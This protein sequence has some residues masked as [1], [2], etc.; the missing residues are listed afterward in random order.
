MQNGG[1]AASVSVLGSVFPM[2]GVMADGT[3]KGRLRSALDM[4]IAATAE[5]NDRVVV[6]DN[7]KD[8]TGIRLPQSASGWRRY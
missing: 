5:P 4:V 2:V 6:T 3:G 8:F 1:L 7:Q